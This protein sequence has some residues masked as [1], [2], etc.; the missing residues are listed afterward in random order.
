MK[1]DDSKGN[2]FDRNKHPSYFLS[3]VLRVHAVWEWNPIFHE[4]ARIV[5]LATVHNAVVSYPCILSHIT[6]RLTM[7]TQVTDMGTNNANNQYPPNG[8]VIL[9]DVAQY[10]WILYR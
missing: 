1:V 7:Q 10:T 9:T 3:S 4:R 6:V 2:K 8:T 5:Q